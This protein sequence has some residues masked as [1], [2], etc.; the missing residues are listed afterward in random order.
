MVRIFKAIG[1][2]AD[3]ARDGPTL[4][5]AWPGTDKLVRLRVTRAQFR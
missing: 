1:R 4:R 2:D 5:E 3:L